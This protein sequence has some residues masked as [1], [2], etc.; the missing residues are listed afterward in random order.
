MPRDFLS[1]WTSAEDAGRLDDTLQ[2]LADNYA[3]SAEYRFQQ[4][5]LW[6]PCLIYAG[7]AVFLVLSIMRLA[8][9]VMGA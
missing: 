8:T 2:R 3:D 4:I 9:G 6:I 7:V 1:L 5:A